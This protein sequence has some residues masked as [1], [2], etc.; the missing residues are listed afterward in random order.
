MDKRALQVGS[1]LS[2]AETGEFDA[3]A[4]KYKAIQDA[5]KFMGEAPYRNDPELDA[6]VIRQGLL[7]EET[8]SKPQ[9]KIVD[10]KDVE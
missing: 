10:R 1:A 8:S 5:R 6:L 7:N 4:I 9:L 3:E 2:G